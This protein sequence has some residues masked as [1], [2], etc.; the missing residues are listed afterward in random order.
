M[1]SK[2]PSTKKL[3]SLTKQPQQQ[4]KRKN[5]KTKK[6]QHTIIFLIEKINFLY[7]QPFLKNINQ[8]NPFGANITNQYLTN[9]LSHNELVYFC[10]VFLSGFY[11]YQKKEKKKLYIHPKDYF[12]PRIGHVCVFIF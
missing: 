2:D 12:F 6:I 5:N 4:T 8:S 9:S 1:G 11:S 7:I 3:L 10:L